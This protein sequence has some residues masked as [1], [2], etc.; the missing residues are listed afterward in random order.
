[1]AKVTKLSA[2]AGAT[3]VADENIDVTK[4]PMGDKEYRIDVS[5]QRP[6]R[7]MVFYWCDRPDA[8]VRAADDKMH[9]H[10]DSD[11]PTL[12]EAQKRLAELKAGGKRRSIM[13]LTGLSIAKH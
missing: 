7:F 4:F 13:D 5:F 6:Y 12:A 8:H 1:M 11:Y 3:N 10:P 9:W 2:D